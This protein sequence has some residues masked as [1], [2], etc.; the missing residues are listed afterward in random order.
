MDINS[1]NDA[2]VKSEKAE[3]KLKAAREVEEEG[4]E[5]DDEEDDVAVRDAEL[6]ILIRE[7]LTWNSSSFTT[8]GSGSQN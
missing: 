4:E 7:L 3:A 8:K 2:R 1:D 5:E 6:W